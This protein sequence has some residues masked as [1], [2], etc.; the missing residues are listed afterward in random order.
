MSG[1]YSSHGPQDPKSQRKTS[2]KDSTFLGQLAS[3]VILHSWISISPKV[4]I[5]VQKMVLA[6]VQLCSAQR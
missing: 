2:L 5:Q 4:L 6:I 1:A 3:S